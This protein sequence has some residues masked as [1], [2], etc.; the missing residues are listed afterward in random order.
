MPRYEAHTVIERPTVER[1]TKL[2]VNAPGRDEVGRDEVVYE[3]EAKFTDGTV[4]AV[5]VC[6]DNEPDILAGAKPFFSRPAT[7]GTFTR[8]RAQTLK[9]ARGATGNSRRAGTSTGS[10]WNQKPE[11]DPLDLYH[12]RPIVSV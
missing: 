4:I 2:C 3:W 1:V 9:N 12:T 7:R 11:L 6:A 10:K 5:Q 8:F